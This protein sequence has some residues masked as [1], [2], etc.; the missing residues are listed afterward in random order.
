M[1]NYGPQ[2]PEHLSDEMKDWWR[3]V[4]EDFELD[5]HHLKLLKLACESYDRAEQAR[6]HLAIYGTTFVDRFNQP[7]SRPEI[8]IENDSRIT[9]ARLL[10]ELNLTGADLPRPPGTR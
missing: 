2:P 1:K 8:K 9:F 10:R 4:V 5:T 7:R 6:I 3:S